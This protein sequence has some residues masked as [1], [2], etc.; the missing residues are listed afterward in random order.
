MSKQLSNEAMGMG[1]LY[2]VLCA[3]VESEHTPFHT[4]EAI[5]RTLGK[6]F[7]DEDGPFMA[8]ENMMGMTNSMID[9]LNTIVH[10]K[11]K[12]KRVKAGESILDNINWN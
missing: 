7:N 4:T 2:S 11:N 10:N 8:D 12:P 5:M 3:V 6:L 1:Q 9:N